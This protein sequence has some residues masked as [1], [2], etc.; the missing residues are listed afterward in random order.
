MK[1]G[2]LRRRRVLLK[3]YRRYLDA[4]SDLRTAQEEA[5]RW[6]PQ[7]SRPQV[8][9]IGQPGSRVRQLHDRRERALA[10][11]VAIRQMLPETRRGA[12]R[13]VQILSLP[14]H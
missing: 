10:R 1:V 4:E 11:L 8:L 12:Y 7:N 5:L 6:F 3:A 13:T 9:P 14:S 2:H